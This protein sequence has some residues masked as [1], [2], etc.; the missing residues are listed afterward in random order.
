MTGIWNLE[1]IKYRSRSVDGRI[2]GH[3]TI[4]LLDYGVTARAVSVTF[5]NGM[6]VALFS[7]GNGPQQAGAP[8]VITFDSYAAQRVFSDAVW[9]LVIAAHPNMAA[10]AMRQSPTEHQAMEYNA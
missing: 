7:Q 9:T 2:K 6:P 4:R 10:A 3:A 8:A 1:L 5:Q